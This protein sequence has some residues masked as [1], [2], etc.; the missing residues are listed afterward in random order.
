MDWFLYDRDLKEFKIFLFFA[1]LLISSTIKKSS[2]FWNAWK[3]ELKA[4]WRPTFSTHC[5]MMWTLGSGFLSYENILWRNVDELFI[6][7]LQYDIIFK[8]V[9]LQFKGNSILKKSTKDGQK[10]LFIAFSNLAPPIV[11]QTLVFSRSG[12]PHSFTYNC[13]ET[14][15]FLK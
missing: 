1:F 4:S 10:F 15:F 14:F 8:L 11:T 7:S 9:N 2:S 13:F 6:A 5:K 12:R 3:I